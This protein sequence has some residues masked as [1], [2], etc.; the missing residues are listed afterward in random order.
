MQ[1]NFTSP[2]T[3]LGNWLRTVVIAAVAV[4]SLPAFAQADL[5]GRVIR[6]VDGDTVVVLDAAK[7]Q[8]KIRMQG[9][10]APESGQAFGKVSRQMLADMIAG[11]TV[12]VRSNASDLYG[13]ML[14]VIM[15]NGNDINLQMVVKGG[16]WH[17]KRYERDQRPTD[18]LLYSQAEISA[19]S[20]RAGLWRDASPTPPWDFRKTAR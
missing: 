18:R 2:K 17:Y 7:Q 1:F 8:F 19:R 4:C 13:R 12:Q 16:A 14:G 11:H 3:F 5:T 15:L 6:V 9:I 20:T 10:D